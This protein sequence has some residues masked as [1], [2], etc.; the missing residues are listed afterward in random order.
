MLTKILIELEIEEQTP[1][2]AR[3]VVDAILD[4]GVLQDEIHE[5]DSDAG[6]L[7]VVSAVV[8]GPQDGDGTMYIDAMDLS[9]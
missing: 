1:G 9:R 8:D 3:F 5:H 6:P 4:S 2:D 7:C